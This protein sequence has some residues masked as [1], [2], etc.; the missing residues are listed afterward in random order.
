MQ[1]KE[2]QKEESVDSIQ[3]HIDSQIQN[4]SGLSYIHCPY[5]QHISL[6]NKNFTSNKEIIIVVS[7]DHHTNCTGYL[8]IRLDRLFIT[9]LR[10]LYMYLQFDIVIVELA[11]HSHD[12]TIAQHDFV[13]RLQQLTKQF[14][15]HCI[16][17]DR[18]NRDLCSRWPIFSMVIVWQKTHQKFIVIV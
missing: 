17:I 13:L 11:P 2:F 14:S 1:N 7:Y 16:I 9:K 15:L 3:E 5:P 18:S 8:F 12:T 4:E 10:F 6:R